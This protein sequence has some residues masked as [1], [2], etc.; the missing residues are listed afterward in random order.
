[1]AYTEIPGDENSKDNWREAL[2]DQI[3]NYL[4]GTR[5][6]LGSDLS[7]AELGE[8][9]KIWELSPERLISAEA[10]ETLELLC[11][12]TE[13]WHHQVF[14]DGSAKAFAESRFKDE[15]QVHVYKLS[16][17]PLAKWIDLAI[18]DLENLPDQVRF[19]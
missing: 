17:S 2:S 5:L 18:T 4:P 14:L 12:E 15:N 11:K 3:A 8:S 10:G 19:L 6:Q 16:I 9:F 1:M 7:D 13:R